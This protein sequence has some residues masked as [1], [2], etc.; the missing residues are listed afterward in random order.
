MGE[1]QDFQLKEG[2]TPSVRSSGSPLVD[3]YCR[4]QS[5][6]ASASGQTETVSKF[7]LM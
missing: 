3:P 4:Q 2:H 6:N 1:L 5:C 7:R